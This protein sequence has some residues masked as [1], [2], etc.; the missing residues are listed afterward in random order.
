MYS[1]LGKP[2]HE[3]RSCRGEG[4]RV[5]GQPQ[6]YVTRSLIL[7]VGSTLLNRSERRDQ[8]KSDRND[9]P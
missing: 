3:S 7:P 2:L 8:T 1:G 4:A 5:P 9:P 6:G